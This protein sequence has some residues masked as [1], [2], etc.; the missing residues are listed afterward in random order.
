MARIRRLSYALALFLVALPS[1][2][3]WRVVDSLEQG[4][5]RHTITLLPTGEVLA[6]GGVANHN[7][8]IEL[9][10]CELLDLETLTWRTALPMAVARYDHT[11]TL[12]P[13][14]EV[15]VAGGHGAEANA[16]ASV[17]LYD[18]AAGTWRMGPP[19]AVARSKHTATRLASGRVL[20]LGGLGLSGNNLATAE[21]YDPATGQWTPAAPMSLG[22]SDHTA[23]R[24]LSGE[25]FVVQDQRAELYDPIDN[26]W[27]PVD[28]PLR[29]HEQHTATLMPSG[30]VLLYNGYEGA[31]SFDS[32]SW[33][34]RTWHKGYWRRRHTANLLSSGTLLIAGSW[35]YPNSLGTLFTLPGDWTT[36]DGL[37]ASYGMTNSLVLPSGEVLLVGGY[38][39]L[40]RTQVYRPIPGTDPQWDAVNS[41][42]LPRSTS[43]LVELADGRVLWVGGHRGAE[44]TSQVEVFDP[45]ANRWFVSASMNEAR[46]RHSATL[47]TNGRVLVAGGRN[48]PG[49]TELVSRGSAELYDPV[50]DLW[51]PAASMRDPRHHHTATLLS[52][53]QVLVAGGRRE[54]GGGGNAYYAEAELYD[55]SSDSWFDAAP[56]RERRYAHSATRLLDGRVLVV[57][58]SNETTTHKSAELY[59]PRTDTWTRTTGIPAKAHEGHIAVALLDGRVLIL[60]GNNGSNDLRTCEIYDPA[61]D[62]FGNAASQPEVVVAQSARRL[63]DGRVLAVGRRTNGDPV[64]YR[65][66]PLGN[67][68]DTLIAPTKPYED[69]ELALL[70]DGNLLLVGNIGTGFG[71]GELYHPGLIPAFEAPEITDFPEV[72]PLGG[73]FTLDGE[74][75]G[76]RFPAS[77][78]STRHSAVDHPLVRL[79]H[80]ESGQVHWLPWEPLEHFTDELT[81]LTVSTLPADLAQ[82]VYRLTIHTSGVGSDAVFTRVDCDLTLDAPLADRLVGPG[83]NATFVAQSSQAISYRWQRD[84]V[85]IPGAAGAT[86]TTPP[87]APAD[88]GSR[89]RVIVTGECGTVV[90]NEATLRVDTAPPS[91]EVLDPNGGELWALSDSSTTRTE[92]IRWMA[93]DDHFLCRARLRLLVSTDGSATFEPVPD[94]DGDPTNDGLLADLG[95]AGCSAPGLSDRSFEVAMPVDPPV[96]DPAARYLVEIEVTDG[97]GQGAVDRSDAPFSIVPRGTVRTLILTHLD[98]MQALHGL[99]A[100]GR[101]AFE[102]SLATLAAHPKVQG[103]VIDLGADPSLVALYDA[104]DT[105]GDPLGANQVLF[106]AEGIHRTIRS[107]IAGPFP[108]VEY[109]ILVGD[110][111]LVPFARIEDRTAWLTESDYPAGPELGTQS[112]VGKALAANLYLS[113][114]PLSVLDTIDPADLDSDLFNPDLLTGRLVETP[115]EIETAIATF[116]ARDGVLDLRD[117]D[118]DTGHKIQV[119]GYDFL[120]DSA[121]QIRRQWR[122]ALDLHPYD[123]NED[124]TPLDGQLVSFDWDLGSKS[125]RR[126]ALEEHLAG[127]P[128]DPDH[129]GGPYGLINL[130]GHATHFE[131]G[132]PGNDP[133][134]IAGLGTERLAALDFTGSLIFA[135]GCHGGL[136]VPGSDPFDG[137]HSL[138][139]PQVFLGG[140]ALAYTANTGYGWG[141]Y[142]GSG[143]GERLVSIFNQELIAGSSHRVGELMQRAKWRYYHEQHRIDAFDL[144]T[145][146]QWALFGF[147]MLTVQTGINGGSP[148]NDS[149]FDLLQ[150]GPAPTL[151]ELPS[152]EALEGATI[153]RQVVRGG[154]TVEGISSPAHL[155]RVAETFYFDASG[156]FTKLDTLGEIVPEGM[157]GCPDPADGAEPGCYYQYHDLATGET[158]LPIQPYTVYDSRLAGTSLHGVLWLGGVYEQEGHWTPIFARLASNTDDGTY[159]AGSTPRSIINRPRG[160]RDDPAEDPDLCR[161]SDLETSSVVLVLGQLETEEDDSYS[162]RLLRQVAVERL[163]FNNNDTGEGNCDRQGPA[164]GNGPYHQLIGDTVEWTVTPPETDDVWRVMVV[165]D[166]GSTGA[167]GEGEWTPLELTNDGSGTWRGQAGPLTNDR[168]IYVL[169]AVDH[170]GNVTWLDYIVTDE[171]LPESGVPLGIPEVVRVEVEGADFDLGLTGSANPD[172]VITGQPLIFDLAATNLG[173]DAANDVEVL[174]TLPSGATYVNAGGTGWTCAPEGGTVLC[175]RAGL[176]KNGTAALSLTVV[177]PSTPGVAS[178][179]AL[180]TANGSDSFS[181]NDTIS[182]AVEVVSGADVMISKTDHGATAL[183]GESFTYTLIATNRGPEPVLGSVVTDLFPLAIVNVTWSC[184]STPG[185][186]CSTS[187]EGDLVDLVDLQSGGAVV[188]TAVGT[189]A[190]DASG[191]IENTATIAPPSETHDPDAGNN[192][193]TVVSLVA[194]PETVLFRDGFESGD[195]SA[196]SS[197]VGA[198]GDAGDGE[199]DKVD[200]ASGGSTNGNSR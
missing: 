12:L 5:W 87:A 199:E 18:P 121:T 155:S 105:N 29:N 50:A 128:N 61:T 95:S 66:D 156:L 56:M 125:D 108:E 152:N 165:Y 99:D 84:G 134:D 112:T 6:A 36:T 188:Y 35:H 4:R 73:T 119:T 151:D 19:M 140:G 157:T 158:D 174:M 169:Q 11:A 96:A 37:G 10:H 124:L 21:I 150:S 45:E 189:V 185:S 107:L 109:L 196:W 179:E 74:H 92:T 8:T 191:T 115:A 187:G 114:D 122:N 106:G 98:R 186:L 178:L 163:Y 183:P 100:A 68:W 147:P 130:N 197:A 173:P 138:D 123:A 71:T 195:L 161:P 30:E 162:Q 47:M 160:L 164:L 38:N 90:S 70:P 15:L 91:V 62:S 33:I 34:A 135:I 154:E 126:D 25:V 193:S 80:T 116:V 83:E 200:G 79:E 43:T 194:L 31:E 182:I 40:S 137:D 86:Y 136:P 58:G 54:I 104:W 81:T 69:T 20:V 198:T 16:L 76:G 148:G 139:L 131:A 181:D 146:M 63:A 110:D 22:R 24:L 3:Q 143:Y 28:P 46:E 57:G 59:D 64:A 7:S 88:S 41:D 167:G 133:F 9:V 52:T 190:N 17:E 23:T 13:T 145:Q 159:D 171:D 97:V 141:L 94:N 113:D 44:S 149:P 102:Q 129:A 89:F 32:G 1:A 78:G 153:R 127:L 53:G 132:V 111:R 144:K 175:H 39:A 51:T 85:D 120:V 180:V 192:V 55:L 67:R 48:E 42:A 168:L 2:A 65:Y 118:P 82:G 166:D 176:V 101:A 49:A 14:G 172:P 170:K 75:L 60:G 103:R 117:L 26:S 27:S 77:S 72:I 142:I 184:V 177:A 93:S